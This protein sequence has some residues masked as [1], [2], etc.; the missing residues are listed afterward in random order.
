MFQERLNG[1]AR[2]LH[3]QTME[4]QVRLPGEVPIAQSPDDPRI[5]THDTTFDVLVR[6]GDIERTFS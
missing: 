3:D 6:V 2:L 1:D 5:E 4:V